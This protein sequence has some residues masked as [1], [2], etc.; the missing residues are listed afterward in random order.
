MA[1]WSPIRRRTKSE[2]MA[3]LTGF[4]MAVEAA[5]ERGLEFARLE[6]KAMTESE[7]RLTDPQ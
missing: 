5:T 1:D 3:L 2:R 4:A 7:E 6:L